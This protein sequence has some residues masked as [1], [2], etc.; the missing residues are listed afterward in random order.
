MIP[1]LN[2]A[3]WNADDLDNAQRKREETEAEHSCEK[4]KLITCLDCILSK[5]VSSKQCQAQAKER[6]KST[7]TD[8]AGKSRVASLAFGVCWNTLKLARVIWRW[9]IQI[10]QVSIHFIFGYIPGYFEP[11]MIFPHE[12]SGYECTSS[13]ALLFAFSYRQNNT[14]WNFFFLVSL[15]QEMSSETCAIA[16]A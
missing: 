15:W 4:V 11:G 8:S 16:T 7:D 6:A 3:C 2:F 9:C 12:E 13:A 14:L 1:D 10:R 5:L